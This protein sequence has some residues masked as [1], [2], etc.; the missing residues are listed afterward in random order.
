MLRFRLQTMPSRFRLPR[1]SA[2]LV[3]PRVE[4]GLI[5]TNR[6]RAGQTQTAND[7]TEAAMWMPLRELDGNSNEAN[8]RHEIVHA[9]GKWLSLSNLLAILGC[10]L[11]WANN[12]NRRD[13]FTYANSGGELRQFRSWAE[14]S[15]TD[16]G[17]GDSWHCFHVVSQAPARPQRG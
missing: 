10:C 9:S 16:W 12:S 13:R 11:S 7:D 5:L 2:R 17:L 1:T 14:G 6:S 3:L 15:T 8:E 4:H